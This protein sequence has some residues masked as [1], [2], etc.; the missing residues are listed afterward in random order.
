M[1]THTCSNCGHTFEHKFCNVCGQAVTHRYTLK[2]VLHEL[3][4]VFTH[5]DKGIFSFGWQLLYRPGYI[6]T[7]L[8]AGRRKR[9]F[10]LFQYLLLV[11]SFATFVVLK[12][13]VFELIAKGM[14]T[15]QQT[16]AQP[17]WLTQVQTDFMG[18]MRTYYNIV[19]LLLIPI[20]A[21]AARLVFNSI[22]SLNY[23]ENIVLQSCVLAS[24]SL[25]SLAVTALFYFVPSVGFIWYTAFAM[26]VTAFFMVLAYKQF[27]GISWL[28]AITN[29]LLAF[30]ISY[31]FQLVATAVAMILYIIVYVV[32]Y[33]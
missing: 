2:H 28:K 6:A 33:K 12:T 3:L 13:N 14:S 27:Y 1:H 22:K 20:Y 18:G 7:D 8:I 5:A 16:A 31:A 4:H 19:N 11:L 29:G 23:A 21:F 24:Y 26:S 9:Y 10:N 30:A 15:Q 25:P 17:A 32:L